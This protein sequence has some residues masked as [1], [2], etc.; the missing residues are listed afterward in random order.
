MVEFNRL[1]LPL[2]KDCSQGKFSFFPMA[3]KKKLKKYLNLPNLE[4]ANITFIVA[5]RNLNQQIPI[6]TIMVGFKT[7]LVTYPFIK[8]GGAKKGWFRRDGQI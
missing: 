8:G 1:N 2:N 5:E 7:V 3:G 4:S 6:G